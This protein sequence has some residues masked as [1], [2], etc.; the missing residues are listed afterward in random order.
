MLT[1]EIILVLVIED[2]STC[3][4]RAS[5]SR[6]QEWPLLSN[7]RD[8]VQLEYRTVYSSTSESSTRFSSDRERECLKKEVWGS[9]DWKDTIIPTNIHFFPYHSSQMY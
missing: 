4:A 9:I 1:Q 3:C 7:D 2:A 6:S 8:V 5:E